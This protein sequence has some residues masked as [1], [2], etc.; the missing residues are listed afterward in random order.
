MVRKRARIGVVLFVFY[1]I[2]FISFIFNFFLI[3]I[4]GTLRTCVG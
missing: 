1:F 4:T 3:L 2:L